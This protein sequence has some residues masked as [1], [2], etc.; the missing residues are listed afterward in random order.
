[1]DEDIQQFLQTI[2]ERQAGSDETIAALMAHLAAQP[3]VVQQQQ[4]NV[5]VLSLHKDL[6]DRIEKFVYS[7]EDNLTFD[8]WYQRYETIFATEAATMTVQQKVDLLTEKLSIADYQ[9]FANT[10]LPLKKDNIP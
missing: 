3:V 2:A 4:Q 9:K 8:L 1:M 5:Q 10:I 7:A 6:S